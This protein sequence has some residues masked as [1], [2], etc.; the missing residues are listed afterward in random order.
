MAVESDFLSNPELEARMSRFA[1]FLI[2]LLVLSAMVVPA[3]VFGINGPPPLRSDDF[4][5]ILLFFVARKQ[6]ARLGRRA[7]S[8]ALTVGMCL[9]LVYVITELIGTLLTLVNRPELFIINGFYIPF[10]YGR[11]MVVF[12]TVGSMRIQARHLWQ[13]VGFLAL[14][15]V[16]EAFVGFLQVNVPSAFTA[17]LF[18]VNRHKDLTTGEAYIRAFGT[19]A[20]PNNYGGVLAALASAALAIGLFAKRNYIRVIGIGATVFMAYVGVVLSQSRTVVFSMGLVIAS[21][22]PLSLFLP[23][24][25]VMPILVLIGLVLLG[26]VGVGVLQS[27][28]LPPRVAALFDTVQ[29]HGVATGVSQSSGRLDI[30]RTHLAILEANGNYWLGVGSSKLFQDDFD[31]GYLMA[32]MTGGIF[33]LMAHCGIYIFMFWISVATIFKGRQSDYAPAVLALFGASLAMATYEVTGGYIAIP[34]LSVFLGVNMGLIAM[35]K[36]AVDQEIAARH[37]AERLGQEWPGGEW[38]GEPRLNEPS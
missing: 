10:M 25:R 8:P 28:E 32:I 37:E 11:T 21:V 4:I 18:K 13:L 23:R 22:L 5:I 26:T 33:A 1:V 35:A 3:L 20:N 30:W 36:R 29:S 16:A 12:I 24:G 31:D 7:F 15:G 14:L 27:I 9:W 2:G 17:F 6:N 19:L 38:S 34:N